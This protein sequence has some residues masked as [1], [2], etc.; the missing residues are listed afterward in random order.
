MPLPWPFKTIDLVP[1][2]SEETGLERDLEY[3]HLLCVFLW[4]RALNEAV[5]LGGIEE[6]R[7][8]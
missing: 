4:H 2:A 8:E 6:H 5:W 3:I 7:E 1:P